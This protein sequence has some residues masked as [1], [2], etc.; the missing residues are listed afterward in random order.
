VISVWYATCCQFLRQIHMENEAIVLY[1]APDKIILEKE[2][3]EEE[4]LGNSMSPFSE[5]ET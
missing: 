4:S 2:V 5:G 1:S 3:E